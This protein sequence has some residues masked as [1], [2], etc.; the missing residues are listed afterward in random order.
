M[1]AWRELSAVRSARGE[2]LA[3]AEAQRRLAA[4]HELRGERE[5]AFAGRRLAA[6][7]FAAGGRPADAAIERLAMANHRRIGADYSEAIELATAAAAEAE[8]AGRQDL[9]ARALG[10]EGVSRAKRGEFEA[11]LETVRSG[12]ALALAHD[13]TAVAAELYQRL[14]LVLY[15]SADYRRA[16]EALDAALGLCRIDGD[17]GTEVA[18]VTC[19]IYVLRERGEWA[20]A[21][22]MCRELIEA[23][24]AAWVA[25][26]LLGTIHGF[27]GKLR[28][29][30]ADARRLAGDL[31][32]A[33]P[34]PHVDRLDRRAR[35]R[36]GRRGRRRRGGRALPPAARALGRLRGP[37][38]RDLGPALG[39]DASWPAAATAPARTCARRR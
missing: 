7:T 28:L 5:A 16:E 12:L 29:R 2:P 4:V 3:Q 6:Q 36:R 8:A 18:C 32:A 17:G 15:D 25:E 11:G 19:L 9:R 14:G 34:L 30:A 39:V 37:P 26:G 10:L 24:N 35:V 23:G 33:R 38:L 27:Q 1:K 31:G 22:E 13:F 20:R 21:A